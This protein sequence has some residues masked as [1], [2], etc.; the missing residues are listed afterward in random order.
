MFFP[1]VSEAV[2]R[3]TAPALRYLNL[4][5][6]VL[7]VFLQRTPALPVAATV[8][9]LAVGSPLGVV[10]KAVISV[11]ALG[12][13]DTLAGAT[14]TTQL[15]STVS[16]PAQ[17]TVGQPFTMAIYIT[18]KGVS[19]AQSWDVTNTLPPGI[20]P[21]GATLTNNQ[22]VLKSTNLTYLTISGTPT[23]AGTY[24]FTA[25]GWQYTN[26]SG[27]VTAGTTQIIVSAPAAGSPSFTTQ[28]Q[29]Q[30]VSI[31]ASVVFSSAATG[32]PSPSYQW[33]K[34]G[35]AISGA[36]NSS[37]SISSVQA[38]DAGSYTVVA[39]NS[40]GSATSNA[41][42]LSVNSTSAPAITMQPVTT[43]GFTG[44]TITLAVAASGTPT[45]TYQ[46]FKDAVAIPGATATTLT[47]T[48]V[49]APDAA[50]Y[51]ATATN[52][53]GMVTSNAVAVAVVPA[54]SQP[55]SIL[56]NLSV[57]TTLA[58]G[59]KLIPGFVTNGSKSLLFRL[60]GPFLNQYGLSGLPD[61][62]LQVYNDVGALTTQNDNWDS[63]L[64]SIFN[65]L[66]A[67]PFTPGSKDS[68]LLTSILGANTAWA[69]GT[70]SGTVLFELYDTNPSD[71]TH[72]LINVSAQNQVGTGADA[73]I[74]GFVVAGTGSKTL[75]IRGIGPKLATYGV[76]GTL[77]DPY[78][79]VLDS[80]GTVV[81]SNDNWNSG[82]SAVFNQV[83]AF[84][85]DS[86]SKDA[87]LLV[88]LPLG[89]YTV[90]LTGVNNGTGRGLL[91]VYEVWP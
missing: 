54:G 84:A 35:T 61:P 5:T 88:T 83:G 50:T 12:A 15:A 13:I 48:N 64:Q 81:A 74:V 44:S 37:Y 89:V 68:S 82:L 59:D 75:L 62:L 52:V 69:L 79:E 77:A 27:P 45:P 87:A 42:V 73:L 32:T 90:K 76:P 67:T 39:S 53:V 41:A 9:R 78:I 47:L 38:S 30:T 57:R 85:L 60:A 71:F 21:A 31:G 1:R 36:T 23:T 51:F 80:G 3:M 25:E 63:S 40:A 56:S 46:W 72:R 8:E 4:P 29:S 14:T 20:T 6:G 2:A 10:L 11:G 66:G 7:L 28:P 55:T 86:G 26:L 65:Q 70:G 49:Q 22:W 58:A 24:T 34:N 19:Y 17:A 18:G 33:K 16:L 91:E 43:N